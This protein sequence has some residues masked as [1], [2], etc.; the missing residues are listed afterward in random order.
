LCD[1]H[2]E[3]I[4]FEINDNV[5]TISNINASSNTNK[6]KNND[7]FVDIAQQLTFDLSDSDLTEEHKLSL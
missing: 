6:H 3:Y 2:E 5:A 7:K 1:I 4:T